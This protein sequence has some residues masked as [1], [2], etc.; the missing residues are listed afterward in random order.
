MSEKNIKSE[1]S[2]RLVE[3]PEGTKIEVSKKGKLKD[4]AM[5]KAMLNNTDSP[6]VKSVMAIFASMAENS[7]KTA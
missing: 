2:I 6:L 3:T 7:P 4:F 5:M 1:I